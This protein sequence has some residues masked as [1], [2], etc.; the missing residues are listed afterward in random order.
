VGNIQA[1]NQLYVT[2]I[3]L[4]AWCDALFIQGFIPLL[5]STG[6]LGKVPELSVKNHKEK[7]K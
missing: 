4:K 2:E 7:N 1:K 5:K 6:S 3:Y